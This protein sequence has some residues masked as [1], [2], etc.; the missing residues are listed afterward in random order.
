M[1]ARQFLPSQQQNALTDRSIP[2][3]TGIGRLRPGTPF[4]QAQAEMKIAAVAL[5]REYPDTNLGQTLVVRHLAEAAYAQLI[6]NLIFAHVLHRVD[7]GVTTFL[8]SFSGR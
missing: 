7:G 3:V 1:M 8:S 4:T 6:L 2:S 5:D